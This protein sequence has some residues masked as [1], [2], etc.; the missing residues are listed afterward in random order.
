MI[1]IYIYSNISE[2][3][4][5]FIFEVHIRSS[6]RDSWWLVSC[7]SQLLLVLAFLPEDISELLSKCFGCCLC[8]V[9]ME[10][11]SDFL[12][13]FHTLNHYQNISRYGRTATPV[14]RKPAYLD[15][16][17]WA[18]VNKSTSIRTPQASIKSFTLRRWRISL[19]MKSTK[20]SRSILSTHCATETRY[21][22][23]M[24]THGTSSALTYC[25]M[26]LLTG[27]RG[28]SSNHTGFTVCLLINFYLNCNI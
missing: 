1:Y 3:Q 23:H 16:C 8:L 25:G 28:S 5:V 22:I 21:D 12:V 24:I 13:K 10:T 6:S 19:F 15:V 11:S 20:R 18:S 7:M 26:T 4:S 17:K 14:T 9:I 2:R 27:Y